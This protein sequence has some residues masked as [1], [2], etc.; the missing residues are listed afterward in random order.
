MVRTGSDQI[1]ESFQGLLVVLSFR[2]DGAEVYA[3]KCIRRI[4]LNYLFIFSYSVL[5]I[6]PVQV[7]SAQEKMGVYI[8]RMFCEIFLAESDG[9]L[10]LVS[11]NI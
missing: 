4:Q 7:Q 9:L 2:I 11:F 8:I 5:I 1:L 3:G 6:L 10:Y